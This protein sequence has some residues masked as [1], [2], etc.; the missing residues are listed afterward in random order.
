[1]TKKAEELYRKA[2]KIGPNEPH[3]I[4]SFAQFLRQL[5]KIEE[6]KTLLK[7]FLQRSPSCGISWHILGELAVQEGYFTDAQK[8]F[9]Q[10]SSNQGKT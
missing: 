3:V 6:T 7:S 10:G 5:G 8:Y 4:N 1:M 2:Q 9:K